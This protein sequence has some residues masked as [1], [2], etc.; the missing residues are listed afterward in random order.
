[1]K[2]TLLFLALLLAGL[3]ADAQGVN[4]SVK[5]YFDLNAVFIHS[6]YM[7]NEQNL[8]ADIQRIKD[9][10][11]Q[12]YVVN[13]VDVRASV[14]PE[15]SR[16][17]NANIQSQR[18]KAMQSYLVEQLGLPLSKV[19][20]TDQAFDWA[21]FRR[22]VAADSKLSGN[23]AF[24]DIID[25]AVAR[26]R[27]GQTVDDQQVT[28]QLRAAN[29]K[30]YSD[31]KRRLFPELRH[32]RA[33]VELVPATAAAQTP[34]DYNNVRVISE[35]VVS[36]T[37]YLLFPDGT[38]Q[39][40]RRE[41]EAAV[42]PEQPSVAEVQPSEQTP[43]PQPETVAPAEP[44]QPVVEPVQPAL[45]TSK[46]YFWAVKTNAL[47][48]LA[49]VPN[50]SLEYSFHPHWSVSG[51]YM[52]AWWKTDRTHKY[53]R[54]YGGN[55]ELRYWL[56]GRK[57][58]TRM[59]GHHVGLYVGALTY[60]FEWG[61]TGYQG[62]KWSTNVGLSYGYSIELAKRLNLDLSIGLGYFSGEYEEYHPEGDYYIWD[63]TKTRKFFGP[64]RAEATFVW[65]LGHGNVN[66]SKLK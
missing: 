27:S 59:S 61:G 25:R 37:E 35:R 5:V 11:S 53:W 36:E 40:I 34:Y 7:G 18:A 32:A 3:A 2:K 15:G 47:F 28:N 26:Q 60:D 16:Q 49:L 43:Q 39:Y 62:H 17:V 14:S 41:G 12:G 24:L 51:E 58:G 57:E 52:H 30:A 1:M 65:K 45:G 48:D 33:Y 50:V 31:M 42:E 23:Q 8:K 66:R 29:P 44:A 21:A 22:L 64:T 19:H 9:K 63:A 55:V 4:D 38:R 13:E 56:K 46:N 54:T 6:D 10:L 20:I